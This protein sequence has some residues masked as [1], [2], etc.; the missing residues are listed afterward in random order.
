MIRLQNTL[1]TLS[2]HMMTKVRN[3]SDTTRVEEDGIS[4]NL[5]IIIVSVQ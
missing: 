4:R 2:H 1:Y 3:N 5:N